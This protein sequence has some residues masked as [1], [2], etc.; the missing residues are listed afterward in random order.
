MDK[1]LLSE[2][3]RNREIM[4]LG[5]LLI[6]EFIQETTG[7]ILT[8]QEVENLDLD[9]FL[10]AILQDNR[11][12]FWDWLKQ[13]GYDDMKY[14][15]SQ[16]SFSKAIA[17]AYNKIYGEELSLD[18]LHVYQNGFLKPQGIGKQNNSKDNAI[19]GGIDIIVLSNKPGSSK[20]EV[21]MTFAPLGWDE[22]LLPLDEALM[23]IN[24]Y[25][26]AN[27]GQQQIYKIKP[28]VSTTQ[29]YRKYKNAST[30]DDRY[31]IRAK[32]LVNR[33]ATYAKTHKLILFSTDRKVTTID[34]GE[35]GTLQIAGQVVKIPGDQLFADVA[36][37]PNG[38]VI[39]DAI[40]ELVAQA[41]G[42]EVKTIKIHSSASNDTIKDPETFKTNVPQYKN[43]TDAV[44]QAADT[45]A[46]FTEQDLNSNPTG[47]R[48]LA[49]I[50]GQ[51]VAELLKNVDLLK[52]ADIEYIYEVGG[53]GD[54]NQ[55]ANLE[56]MAMEDPKIEV[57]KGGSTSETTKI[58]QKSSNSRKRS[59]KGTRS[60]D[61]NIIDVFKASFTFDQSPVTAEV[62]A[63]KKIWPPSE[64]FKSKKKRTTTVDRQDLLKRQSS[65]KTKQQSG[66]I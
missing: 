47:N 37:E 29:T 41:Q 20:Y 58:I 15:K 39:K 31:A 43:W 3:N 25:N 52:N 19:Y 59:G 62:T 32:S 66:E 9:V 21:T 16:M 40:A 56:I 12:P 49:Y 2:I 38:N 5:Q 48:A 11:K 64:W 23:K 50:R 45:E 10:P 13:R 33:L 54:D 44:I 46:Q 53:S 60:Y 22:T 30:S 8:E 28:D 36:V 63:K 42:K 55:F 6:K 18:S 1:K 34:A 17:Y 7:R 61:Q 65:T 51:K 24:Q 57:L 14:G 4:G 26:I 27:A 35:G